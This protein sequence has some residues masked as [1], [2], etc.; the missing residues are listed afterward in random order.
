[1]DALKL[2]LRAKDQLHPI[3]SELMSSYAKLNKSSEWEG[4]PKILQWCVL[5]GS[6]SFLF[7]C[8]H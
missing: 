1:M 6:A 5:G 7:G 8:S 4:R 2:K 3:L